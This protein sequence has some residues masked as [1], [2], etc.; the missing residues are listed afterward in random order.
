ML[1]ST[2]EQIEHYHKKGL[3]K[4]LRLD[5][6]FASHAEAM[7]EELAL[8]DD[9]SLYDVT[10]RQPQCLSFAR[11]NRRSI[12]LTNFLTGI[13]MKPDT[14][15]AMLLPP[16]VDAAVLTLAASRM[17][18][19]LAPL[20]PMLQEADLRQKLEQVNAKAIVCCTHFEDEPVA[21]R[22]RNVAADM[23][24]I[25]FVFC[26]GDGV[27]DGLIELAPM[28]DDESA[29]DDEAP[30]PGPVLR[31]AN[32]VLAVQWLSATSQNSLPLGRSHNE[33]LSCAR[34]IIE[35]IGTGSGESLLLA[36]QLYGLVGFGAGLVGGLSAGARMIFHHFMTPARLASCLEEFGCQHVMV[37]E[38]QWPAIQE[39]LP[40]VVREQLLSVSILWNRLHPEGEI[41]RD[42]ETAAR[43]IDITNFNEL[44]LVAQLRRDP[45]TIDSIPIGAIPA[46]QGND[47]AWLE[48]ALYGLEET[49][50][51]LGATA[52]GGELCLKGAMIPLRSFPVAG[53]VE[54]DPLPTKIEGY[55][56]TRI[57][58]RAVD[59]ET[60]NPA[61]RP[62]GDL[63]DILSLGGL[64]ERA[65]DLDILYR[66]CDGV[67]D[68][69]SFLMEQDDG[70]I[71]VLMA[72]LVVEDRDEAEARF[73]QT[74]E[75]K[76]VSNHK[77]PRGLVFVEA[78]PKKTDGSI[79]RTELVAAAL[80]KQVA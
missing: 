19:I 37:P 73:F 48:T 63:A 59:A 52:A 71:P 29:V 7:P 9:Q 64:N 51:Q 57:G 28:M 45:A 77:W 43:L 35:Q 11:A 2:P 24:S 66:A 21:E 55:V 20:S 14:V 3:W 38:S 74:L 18:F 68:A 4:D 34:H 27:P 75:E 23:F 31:T 65:E 32:S 79:L 13:G 80:S 61:F 26:L 15:V 72:A 16:C 60:D 6:I 33:Y 1:L 49:R 40:M 39:S 44:A 54:G 17:G 56:E 22:I 69:A 30:S 58:C 67:L 78:I 12:G 36:Y 8:I 46:R 41:Y 25:R 10:G 76:Q 50:A 47:A 5:Q 53:A 42:N 62:L 70:G